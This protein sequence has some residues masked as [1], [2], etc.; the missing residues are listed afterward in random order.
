MRRSISGNRNICFRQIHERDLI[1]HLLPEGL[2]YRQ[3]PESEADHST[4]TAA[5]LSYKYPPTY[6]SMVWRS[7]KGR[8]ILHLRNFEFTVMES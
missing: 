3:R 1:I 2:F 5:K 7:I 6:T 4:T 8:E